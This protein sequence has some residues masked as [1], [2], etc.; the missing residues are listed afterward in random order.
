MFEHATPRG[1]KA[2]Q[3]AEHESEVEQAERRC[4]KRFGL[5]RQDKKQNSPRGLHVYIV[6]YYFVGCIRV[7]LS[8]RLGFYMCLLTVSQ[9]SVCDLCQHAN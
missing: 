1:T 4:V 9:A 7:V 3:L 6:L 2:L 8:T 5:L